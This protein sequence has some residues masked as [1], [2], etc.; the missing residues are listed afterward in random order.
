VN[1][2]LHKIEEPDPTSPYLYM[3][4]KLECISVCIELLTGISRT[5]R[6]ARQQA[7]AGENL[8]PRA[9][10]MDQNRLTKPALRVFL[11]GRTILVEA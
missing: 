2:L 10:G 3:A 11:Q 7:T 9:G 6:T 8:K 5:E 1:P 4:A